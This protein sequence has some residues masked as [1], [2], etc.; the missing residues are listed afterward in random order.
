MSWI[1][2]TF[3]AFGLNIGSTQP[4]SIAHEKFYYVYNSEVP[5][6]L[7]LLG[8]LEMIFGEIRFILPHGK[9]NAIQGAFLTDLQV[10]GYHESQIPLNLRGEKPKAQVLLWGKELEKYCFVCVSFY[11]YL[12]KIFAKLFLWTKQYPKPLL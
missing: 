8:N 2:A 3:S 12:V 5:V 9:I 6:K 11:I 10:L 7:I 4:I 1:R